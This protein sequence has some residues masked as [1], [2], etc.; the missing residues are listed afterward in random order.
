MD[1]TRK[2]TRENFEDEIPTVSNRPYR[3]LIP[4][5]NHPTENFEP[6]SDAIDALLKK[7][8]DSKI[9]NIKAYGKAI[10]ENSEVL[11][12]ESGQEVQVI[13]VQEENSDGPEED[14]ETIDSTVEFSE[15]HA[16]P[17][18]QM[19][20]TDIL[21]SYGVTQDLSLFSCFLCDF[22]TGVRSLIARHMGTHKKL[23]AYQCEF[24][25]W[26]HN[27]KDRLRQHI[28]IKHRLEEMTE[29]DLCYKINLDAVEEMRKIA[30]RLEG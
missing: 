23:Y 7:T 10:A 29:V 18:V 22:K 15:F 30:P 9:S 14:I 13:N 25:G 5:K 2:R 17:E 16:D 3:P 24:C 11:D 4:T 19:D 12:Y 8:I 27:S 1:N 21:F 28:S 6:Y 26:Q 20:P